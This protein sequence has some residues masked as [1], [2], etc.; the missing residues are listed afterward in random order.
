M[1][2]CCFILII[3]SKNFDIAIQKSNTIYYIFEFSTN[4][5]I[6]RSLAYKMENIWSENISFNKVKIL[7]DLNGVEFLNVQGIYY[8]IS[9]REDILKVYI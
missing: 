6:L 8:N 1:K 5:F 3:P 4:Y 9:L 7:Y 2:L